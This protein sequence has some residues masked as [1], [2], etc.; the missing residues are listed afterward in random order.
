MNEPTKTR[1]FVVDRIE[2]SVVVLV[3]D[4]EGAAALEVA[5]RALPDGL[6]EGD[7]LRVPMLEGAG[8]QS[9]APLWEKAVVDRGERAGRETEAQEV[10]ERLKGRDPGGDVVL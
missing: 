3:E 2:G 4:A 6:R 10:L 1:V 5:R 9:G 7:V 8:S